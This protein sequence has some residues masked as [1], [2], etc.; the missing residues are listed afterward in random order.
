MGETFRLKNAKGLFV[1]LTPWAIVSVAT[2]EGLRAEVLPTFSGP[3]LREFELAL[4]AVESLPKL[5]QHLDF[6]KFDQGFDLAKRADFLAAQKNGGYAWHGDSVLAYGWFSPESPKGASGAGYPCSNAKE[7]GWLSIGKVASRIGAINE[8]LGRAGADPIYN[9]RYRGA[10][11]A[12]KRAKEVIFERVEAARDFGAA[13]AW[14]LFCGGPGAGFMDSK[15]CFGPMARARS[16][17]SPAAAARTAKSRN[18]GIWKVVR[19]KME[20]SGVESFPGDQTDDALAGA[21]A[22]RES[23]A[24][25]K[26]LE[27][28]SEEDLKE[29][30]GQIEGEGPEH[31]A[32]ARSRAARL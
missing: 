10:K 8:M 27:T 31:P 32:P 5:S 4:E 1:S 29:R 13:E 17:E 9:F 30:L 20:L 14:L 12:A 18:L 23:E 26:A 25:R 28:A 21:L 19:V 11:T 6:T 2:V 15:G 16:F 24:L 22:G 7:A 3:Q